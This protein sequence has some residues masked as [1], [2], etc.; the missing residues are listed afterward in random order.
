MRDLA[1][2]VF[3]PTLTERG[4]AEALRS[5][6]DKANL[7]ATLDDG[8]EGARFDATT[9]AAVYFCIREALQNASKHA[10]ESP[11][12]L[13]LAYDPGTSTLTFAVRDNGPGF[14]AATVK[15]GSGLQNMVDRVEAL[16]GTLAFATEAGRGTTVMGSVPVAPLSSPVTVTLS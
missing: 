5:H 14:D 4:L 11:L 3:P 12:T 7:P 6:I 8:L 10:P 13:Q 9:E 16:D 1:R 15:R 2:G